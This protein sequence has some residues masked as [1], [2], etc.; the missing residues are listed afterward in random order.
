[1]QL[2]SQDALH[3]ASQVAS[4]GVPSQWP[5]HCP[6]QLDSQ[7]PSHSAALALAEQSPEQVALQS[8]LQLPSQSKLPG[9]TMHCPEQ[10]ASQLPLHWASKL[11][12]QLPEH[13]ALQ[14]AVRLIGVH[15]ASHPPETLNSHEDVL[16]MTTS[17][18]FVWHTAPASALDAERMGTATNTAPASK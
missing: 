3:L 14:L 12:L 5:L 6:E 1:M 11:A 10:S 17:P 13:L 16:V 18:S 2:P 8:A 9:S 15:S 7:V 4:G